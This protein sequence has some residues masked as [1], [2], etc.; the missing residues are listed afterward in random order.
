MPCGVCTEYSL[1]SAIEESAVEEESRSSTPAA[2]EDKPAT[3]VNTPSGA[4]T[5]RTNASKPRHSIHHHR[6]LGHR[7]RWR[8]A[9]AQPRLP[10]TAVLLQS[11]FY[12]GDKSSN[13]SKLSPLP[14]ILLLSLLSTPLPDPP[15]P[16]ELPS[17]S[18]KQLFQPP[19]PFQPSCY[20]SRAATAV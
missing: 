19:T 2:H 20:R 9:P 14:V 3:D 8:A 1:D 15:L 4:P 10:Q 5:V 18:S 16:S 6:R 13:R 7:H 12:I 17:G 11:D